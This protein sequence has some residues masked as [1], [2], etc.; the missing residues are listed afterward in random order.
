MQHLLQPGQ[1]RLLY[2]C[3]VGITGFCILYRVSDLVRD[4]HGC[5]F[6]F[7]TSSLVYFNVSTKYKLAENIF[8]GSE[9]QLIR[10]TL[11]ALF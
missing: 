7:L 2:T 4:L 9:L 5:F 6:T 1:V 10:H 3:T 11:Y 8:V